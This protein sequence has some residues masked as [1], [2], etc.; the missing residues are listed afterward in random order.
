MVGVGLVACSEIHRCK[1]GAVHDIINSK[2]GNS[3]QIGSAHSKPAFESIVE[4]TGKLPVNERGW[5]VVKV[6]G[7]NNRVRAVSDMFGYFLG[8]ACPPDKGPP[9]PTKDNAAILLEIT[10]L[11]FMQGVDHIIYKEVILAAKSDGFKVQVV[12]PYGIFSNFDIG[13]DTEISGVCSEHDLAPVH[14]G[15]GAEGR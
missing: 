1:F 5:G 15:V 13:I 10:I 4:F 12:N 3:N 7:Q 2:T 9:E 8:L 6:A 14:D 11:S